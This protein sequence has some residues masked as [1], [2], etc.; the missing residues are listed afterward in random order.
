MPAY[1]KITNLF[2]HQLILKNQTSLLFYVE[3]DWVSNDPNKWYQ[4][5]D[6][7]PNDVVNVG[8]TIPINLQSNEVDPKA[9]PEA[10]YR[11]FSRWFHVR[12]T[13]TESISCMK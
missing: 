7:S 10:L 11:K 4:S 1:K 8:G 13:C 3:H 9:F 6:H 2:Y 12:Q 5:N